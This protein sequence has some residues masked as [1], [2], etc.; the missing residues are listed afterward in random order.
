MSRCVYLWR[1]DSDHPGFEPDGEQSRNYGANLWMVSAG[2]GSGYPE[3]YSFRSSINNGVALCWNPYQPEITQDWPLA[4]P[5]KQKEP[6]QLKKVPRQTVADVRE[7]YMV[8]EPFPWDSA[9]RLATEFKRI[10]PLFYGD[11][12]PLTPYSPA[13]EDWM[14]YQ[15]HREDLREGMVLAFRRS[16]S[17]AKQAKLN[18]G[19]L[20]PNATYEVRIEDT[21][22]TFTTT[23]QKL[24]E[25][26][27]VTITDQPGSQLITYRQAL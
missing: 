26:L 10:R 18:L 17:G 6:Y 14:A 25:G 3:T 24:A 4:H 5:V 21:G 1:S 20:V 2:T 27:D 12:Y 13:A 19:G 9:E 7:G 8:S 23:G 15:Y 16:K 22:K 11:F